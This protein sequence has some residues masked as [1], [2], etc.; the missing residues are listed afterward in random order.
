MTGKT[1]GLKWFGVALADKFP[2]VGS[3]IERMG[4]LRVLVGGGSMY[5]SIP[6]FFLVHFLGH[7][8]L[9][10]RLLAPL[11]QLPQVEAKNYIILDRHKID[12]LH[13]FDKGN[14]LF[15]GWANGLSML[16]YAWLAEFD[17]VEDEFTPGQKIAA[18]AA[19]AVFLPAIA[20][21]EG[22][23]IQV[24]YNILVSRPLGMRRMSLRESLA[25]AREAGFA[26]QYRGLARAL[27]RYQKSVDLRLENAL[28]QIESSWCPLKHLDERPEVVYPPHHK[29]FF[30]PDQIEE[31][32]ETLRTVGTVSERKPYW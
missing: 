32:K 31:M 9:L 26:R 1:T 2:I 4:L 8:L 23:G 10:R 27:L 18:G 30:R 5:L 6:M 17:K 7:H 13:W 20:L 28:E 12:G 21:A 16:M 14:C 25:Q 15:C 22:L 24:I 3:Q 11:L 29:N 19:S